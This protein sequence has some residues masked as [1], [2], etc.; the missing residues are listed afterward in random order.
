MAGIENPAK[1]IDVVENYDA[2]SHQTLMWMERLLLVPENEAPKAL[3][4]GRF[5][6]D[7]DIPVNPSGG[8]VSTNAIGCTA[9]IRP[10]EAALQVMELAGERQLK[11]KVRKAVAHGWGGLFQFNTVMV[12]GENP[13]R[14]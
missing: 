2:W 12:L 7:G 1:E 14:W 9:M 6:M 8:V 5:Y 3:R 13:R 11:K 10:A 4:E